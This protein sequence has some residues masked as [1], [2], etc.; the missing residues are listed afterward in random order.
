VRF[1]SLARLATLVALCAIA[2][3]AAWAQT[4]TLEKIKQTQKIVIGTR[5]SSPPL[6]FTLGNAKYAGYHI[7]ICKTIAA[8]IKKELKLNTLTIEY[9]AVTSQNRLSLMR[10]GS[11]DLEC[12]S[13]TNN[14][15]RQTQVAFAPTTFITH[16]RLLVKADSPIRSIKDLGGKTV[17][18][19]SGTTSV[20]LL[21]K[22]ERATGIQ[23]K[24]IFG[25]DH[26]ECL[27]L[28]ATDRAD[29]FVMDDNTLL[30]LMA[31]SPPGAYKVV[32][33]ELSEEPIAIM[34]RKDDAPFKKLVD[35]T[36]RRM[37][38]NGEINTLYE[39]WFNAPMSDMLQSVIEQPNDRPAESYKK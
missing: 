24:Q 27:L 38:Q 5:E 30:G 22:H 21:R 3:Q 18:T 8:D 33:E 25:K 34:L 2:N 37:M 35:R 7:D 26:A 15:G 29:A 17:T 14:M 16:A 39:K 32:G 28:V 23:I 10:N 13:T 4:D 36:V 9:M 19:T 1:F 6:A 20:L 11:I 12:G 31:N